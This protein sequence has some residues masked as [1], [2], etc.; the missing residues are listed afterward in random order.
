MFR[1]LRTLGRRSQFEPAKRE[2]RPKVEQA[3]KEIKRIARIKCRSA[4]VFTIGAYY[5]HPRHLAFWITTPTDAERDDLRKDDQMIA[6]FREALRGVD[7][8]EEAIPLIGF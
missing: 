7:Y 4:G 5:V 2:L 8:P 1:F 6:Q 3:E